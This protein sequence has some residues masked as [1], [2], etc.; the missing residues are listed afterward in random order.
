VRSRRP[1]QGRPI[2][3]PNWPPLE[4]RRQTAGSPPG[5]GRNRVGDG[6]TP[7]PPPIGGRPVHPVDRPGCVE[8]VIEV[9]L[10]GALWAHGPPSLG[11][12]C[13][14][15]IAS[16]GLLPRSVVDGRRRA[17]SPAMRAL[18][19]R[20]RA[21]VEA[22]ANTLRAE[23]RASRGWTSAVGASGPGIATEHVVEQGGTEHRC[24]GRC[25]RTAGAGGRH[26]P[27]RLHF[28]GAHCRARDRPACRTDPHSVV[29][30]LVKTAA[31]PF[32]P[33][34]HRTGFPS[35]RCRTPHDCIALAERGRERGTPPAAASATVGR[36]GAGDHA[37][38]GK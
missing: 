20:A 7:K 8:K 31:G 34:I 24:S 2:C 25:A 21:G 36:V 16:R 18:Q 38:R 26:A 3:G 11:V 23:V 17:T 5:T 6:P 29:V 12:A 37:C 9:D 22:F 35:H 28:A 4:G 13:R 15:L 1:P 10:L 19:R 33:P 27:N 14:H 30:A 32:L